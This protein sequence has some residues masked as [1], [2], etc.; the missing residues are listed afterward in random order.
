MNILIIGQ[1]PKEAGGDFTT[2]VGKVIYELMQYDEDICIH[3]YAMNAK[4]SNAIVNN[5]G[6]VFYYGYTNV[7]HLIIRDFLL[8][9]IRTC[10]EWKHF[11][12]KNHRNPIK[13]HF[14]KCI[15]ERL[16]KE[17]NPN[18]I[19]VHSVKMLA[20]THFANHYNIP[21]VQTFHGVFY[22]GDPKDIKGH[23]LYFGNV[24]FIN[25]ATVLTE[26]MKME[27]ISVGVDRNLIEIIPNGVNTRKFFYSSE[28]RKNIRLQYNTPDNCPVFLTVGSVQY[29]KGQLEFLN[30]LYSLHIDFRYWIIGTGPD[31]EKV[32]QYARKMNIEDKIKMIGYVDNDELFKYYSAADIYAHASHAEGQALSEIEA[33]TTGLRT[34][35]NKEIAGT[36]NSGINNNSKYFILD[37]SYPDLPKLKEWIKTENENRLS[38]S[39]YDW[40]VIL[41]KYISFYKKILLNTK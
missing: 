21:I 8:H 6:S 15:I 34:I 25:Y 35:V 39:S 37:F 20:S 30:I 4:H 13:D 12:K 22:K 32:M 38:D 2:G 16:I 33:Y 19:H 9:P 27:A 24:P 11:L 31:E 5:H 28:Q 17:T 14:H 23:D 29:R 1:L 18:L 10:A 3:I 26:E 7:M 36:I 40:Q 41:H